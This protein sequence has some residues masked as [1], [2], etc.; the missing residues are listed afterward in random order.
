MDIRPKSMVKI[1]KVMCGFTC[2]KSPRYPSLVCTLS[3]KRGA[4]AV[5]RDESAHNRY[6]CTAQALVLEVMGHTGDLDHGC[7]DRSVSMSL[8]EREAR[9]RECR[10]IPETVC[11]LDRLPGICMR[12]R[13]NTSS[14][15]RT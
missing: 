6:K 8:A 15:C 3:T 12:C 13:K 9:G 7:Y 1:C 10:R 5:G 4:C 11:A 14:D 2:R